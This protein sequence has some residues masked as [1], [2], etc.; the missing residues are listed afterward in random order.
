MKIDDVAKTVV[1]D[2]DGR[3]LLLR[4]AEDDAN[5]PGE[6]DLPGGGIE[7]GEPPAE[8][9]LREAAEE[10]GLMLQAAQ[11]RLVYA[12]TRLSSDG[13]K[14]VNRFI[15]VSPLPSGQT[16]QLSREHSEYRW[17]TFENALSEYMHPV[18]AEG[19]RY[20]QANGLLPKNIG[21]AE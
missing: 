18:Y 6:W 10:A 4:R 11:L 13:S 16:I 8:A 5:R 12:T 19:L 3:I 2:P 14:S 21:K 1:V 20:A 9:A 17:F 15:F 7:S